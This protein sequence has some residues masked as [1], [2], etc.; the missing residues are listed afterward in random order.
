[1]SV[2]D[3][4]GNTPLVEIRNIWDS[5]RTGV[6]IMAKLEGSNPG[7]SVKDRPAYFMLKEAAASGELSNGKIILEPTSGNTGIGMAMVAAA[8][9]FKIKLTMPTCVSTERRAVLQAL[10]AELELKIGRASCRE[11]VSECV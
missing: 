5:A 10:G 2:L 4:I 11:R 7:G 6:R 1:M 8:M 9:G 3:A